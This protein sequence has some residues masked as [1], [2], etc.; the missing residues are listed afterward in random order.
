MKRRDIVGASAAG[1]V[2]ASVPAWAQDPPFPKPGATLKYV[3]PFAPG[4]LTDVMARAVAQ[5]LTEA[6]KVP[7][8]V[9]NKAGGNAQIGAEQVAKSTPD[10]SS[11]LAITLTHAANVALFPNA[12]YSFVRDLR[13]V[14]LLAGS[15]ML[16]VVPTGSPIKDFKDLVAVAKT[17]QLNAGSS[18]NGTPPHLTM[19]LF[20]DLNKTQMTHVPYRGGAPSMTDL[21]GGQLD[22]IFSNFPESIAH[23]KSGKLRALAICSLSRHAMVPDVPTTMEAGMP[24]LF[25]ENWTAAMIQARTPDVIVDRYSREMIKIM[26]SAE[27]EERAK[28]QGFRVTPK[29]SADFAV[30]LKSEIDRWSRIIRT[31]KITVT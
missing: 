5:K 16:V 4:G 23:V 8:I 21:I 31:A 1:A 15:P 24:G 30:F 9:E 20:N 19:A 28:Q 29:G 22:V 17:R 26:F 3:V 18:G 7:V 2:L 10:G 13:P 6:W 12:P 25:V 11:L 27:V 14:A